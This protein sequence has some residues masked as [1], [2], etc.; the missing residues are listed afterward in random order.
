MGF[1][2]STSYLVVFPATLLHFTRACH[3][4]T[5]THI[6]IYIYIPSQ[7]PRQT[8]KH[9]TSDGSKQILPT[10]IRVSTS[11]ARPPAHT[12]ANTPWLF[13][14]TWILWLV[15][16]RLLIGG[17]GSHTVH[18]LVGKCAKY[19]GLAG[20]VTR[21]QRGNQWTP[22]FLHPGRLRN[23][24]ELYSSVGSFFVCVLII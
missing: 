17:W 13:E 16:P 15:Q 22:V 19:D 14:N 23:S 9:N 7:T 3:T 6:Y 21:T 11:E 5:H 18:R 4:H 1:L 20:T 2:I 10:P 12:S 8:G 24:T